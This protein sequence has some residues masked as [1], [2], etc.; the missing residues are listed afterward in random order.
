MNTTTTNVV[1]TVNAYG[2]KVETD[3]KTLLLQSLVSISKPPALRRQRA[4][5]LNK[6]DDNAVVEKDENMDDFV[7]RLLSDD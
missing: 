4:I 5:S 2:S 1:R 3:V 6:D 7:H